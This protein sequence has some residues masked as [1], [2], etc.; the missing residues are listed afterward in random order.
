MITNFE[1]VS[2]QPQEHGYWLVTGRWHEVV[3]VKG[4]TFLHYLFDGDAPQPGS[5]DLRG[6]RPADVDRMRKTIL[7]WAKLTIRELWRETV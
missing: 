4:Q 7:P 3:N 1:T 6:V 2:F 5:R